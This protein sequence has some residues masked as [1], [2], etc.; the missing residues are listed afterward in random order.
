MNVVA[1]QSYTNSVTR[2]NLTICLTLVISSD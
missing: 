2:K 1:Q